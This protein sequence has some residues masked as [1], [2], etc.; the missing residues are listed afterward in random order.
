LYVFMHEMG[1]QF[2]SPHTHEFCK[3]IPEDPTTIDDCVKSDVCPQTKFGI[4]PSCSA[5]PAFAG[6]GTIMSYCYL[7][8][9]N[10]NN[11][12]LTFGLKHPCG[13]RPERVA[14]VMRAHVLDRAAQFPSCFTPTIPVPPPA[15]PPK[16]NG[17]WSNPIVVPNALPFTST[18][19]NTY[20]PTGVP[21]WD[22]R[23][24][25]DF[26]SGR[27]VHVFRWFATRTYDNAQVTVSSCGR[28]RNDNTPLLSVRSATTAN[29]VG[30]FGC[31][32]S[33]A[34]G[35]PYPDMAAVGT[36]KPVAD[37]FYYLIVTPNDVEAAPPK[38][39]L[40]VTAVLGNARGR[41][42]TP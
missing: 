42:A 20:W 24:C 15:P 25:E 7:L 13:R 27:R 9:G 8:D 14:K 10:D 3:A 28:L 38:L 29:N 19:F 17:K 33:A 41:W 4:L 5:T 35:C 31:V 23:D 36:F 6:A 26:V 40:T 2:G 18:V 11:M 12:A 22:T 21:N 30:P 37:T 1:H 39:N 32:A 16:P 34:Y